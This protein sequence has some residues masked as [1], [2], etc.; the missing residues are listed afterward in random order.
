MESNSESPIIIQMLKNVKQIIETSKERNCWKDEEL[1]EI[2]TTYRNVSEILR[3][4]ENP[5]KMEES[6]KSE[7][8][9]DV[10]MWPPSAA[11]LLSSAPTITLPGCWCGRCPDWPPKGMSITDLQEYN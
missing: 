7:A 4:L 3:K 6:S 2:G 9:A 5:F 1:K 8:L 11:C 10:G